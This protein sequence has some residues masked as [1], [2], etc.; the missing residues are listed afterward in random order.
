[1]PATTATPAR[2]APVSLAADRQQAVAPAT[3]TLTLVPDPPDPFKGLA[4]TA[5]Q[6][7]LRRRRLESKSR[8]VR[9]NPTNAA[10]RYKET[11]ELM[12][13]ARRGFRALRRRIGGGLD[14]AALPELR[15]LAAEADETFK[16]AGAR[17][18]K[19]KANPDGYSWQ[20]IADALGTDK[21]AA[22]RMLH[23]RR[24]PRNP[25]GES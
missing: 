18:H 11:R 1:M 19:S 22:W 20:E 6:R 10:G 7:E 5:L 3:T 4:T 23:K 25:E 8:D 2:E 24:Q 13:M 15:D 16:E 12:G 21:A 14:L 17:L 9:A